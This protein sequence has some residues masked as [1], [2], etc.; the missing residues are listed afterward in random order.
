MQRKMKRTKRDLAA[1]KE[2]NSVDDRA[3]SQKLALD[4]P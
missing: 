4:E 2:F 1:I 3:N